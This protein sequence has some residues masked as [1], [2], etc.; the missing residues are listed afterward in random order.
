MGGTL[1]EGSFAEAA[2][3]KMQDPAVGSRRITRLA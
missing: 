2:L 1:N 3:V